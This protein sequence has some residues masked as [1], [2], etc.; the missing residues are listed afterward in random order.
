VE[1]LQLE[2]KIKTGKPGAREK[3]TNGSKSRERVA[4]PIRTEFDPNSGR[5][6]EKDFRLNRVWASQTHCCVLA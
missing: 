3:E 1:H 6:G 2:K 4:K 5:G